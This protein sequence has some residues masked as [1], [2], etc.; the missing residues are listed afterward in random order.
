MSESTAEIIAEYGPFAGASSIAGVT[1]DGT[2][3]WFASGGSLHSFDPA[4]GNETQ[5]IDVPAHAGCAFDGTYLYQIATGTIQKIDPATGRVVSTLP[6]PSG[7]GDD[8]GLTWAEGALW[9]GQYRARKIVQID[10]DTGAVLRTIESNRF[11]TGVTWL[12]PELWH[13]TAENQASDL[14]RIDPQTGEVLERVEMPAGTMI[15]GLESNGRD[16]FYAGG[17]NGKVVRAIRR[18]R[19]AAR[20]A[21]KDA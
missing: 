17:G 15:S 13:A 14:R 20:A 18:P 3:V 6:A 21:T 16:L 8:S 4:T 19:R 7:G 11:V 5:S 9:V 10:P 12:G 1:Y 2:S